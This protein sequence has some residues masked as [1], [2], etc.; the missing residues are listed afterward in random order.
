MTVEKK[1]NLKSLQLK[2]FMFKGFSKEKI[3]RKWRSTENTKKNSSVYHNSSH[4]VGS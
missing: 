2:L 3:K 4:S 1:N